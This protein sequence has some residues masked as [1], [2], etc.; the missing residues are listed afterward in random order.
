[1]AAYG[2][3]TVSGENGKEYDSWSE[4]GRRE[5]EEGSEG[6]MT[7]VK[8]R[9]GRRR[10]P[11]PSPNP[12]ADYDKRRGQLVGRSCAARYSQWLDARHLQLLQGITRN[13]CDPPGG[14]IGSAVS[15]L[16]SSSSCFEVSPPDALF[17]FSCC[18]PY[19]PW[20]GAGC[21]IGAAKTRRQYIDTAG[22]M[23]DAKP[24]GS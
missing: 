14:G 13:R 8:P 3:F 9:A 23:Q 10:L 19:Q 22:F 11:V 16:I 20:D 17:F 15:M 4:S 2:R 21:V 1:M 7:N 24:I 12:A 5:R 6:R 18:F